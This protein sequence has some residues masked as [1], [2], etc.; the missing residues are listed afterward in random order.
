VVALLK[1]LPETKVT[2]LVGADELREIVEVMK[3]VPRLSFPINSAGE[4][5]AAIGDHQVRVVGMDVDPFRMVKYM[6]AYYFPIA[7]MENFLEKL[8]ELV[9]ANRKVSD[10]PA[11][12]TGLKKQLPPLRYPI[13]NADDLLKAVAPRTSI[14]FQGVT[15]Q[16]ASMRRYLVPE[17]F[18][19]QNEADFDRKVGH[20]ITSRPLIT[21]E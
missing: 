8:A 19:I 11:E 3:G 20:L 16:P 15:V 12:L 2:P 18:P 1:Q 10:V 4:L 17:L 21:R 13:A 9:R 14:R 6:P 7:S 5:M